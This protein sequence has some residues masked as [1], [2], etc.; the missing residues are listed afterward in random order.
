MA[1]LITTSC[2]K[3]SNKRSLSQEQM[4]EY[5]KLLPDY[6]KL[7]NFD[8]NDQIKIASLPPLFKIW[9][10]ETIKINKC[11]KQNLCE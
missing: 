5:I 7:E 6:P 8:K 9:V 1:I 4:Q 3:N 10:Y 2:S 11:L